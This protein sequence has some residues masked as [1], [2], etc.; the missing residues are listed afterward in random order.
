MKIGHTGITWGIPGDVE[1]A[2]GDT[3]ELGYLGFETFAQTI[4]NW[5]EKPGGYRALIERYGIPTAAA[6]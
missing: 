5:N 6:Y 1:Q 3:T 4:L 2:C